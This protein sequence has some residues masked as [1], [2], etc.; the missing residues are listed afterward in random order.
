M[1]QNTLA[2][3]NL[4]KV[5]GYI[6]AQ[7]WNALP[8][9]GNRQVGELNARQVRAMMIVYLRDKEGK[10]PLTLGE[11]GAQLGMRKAAASLLVSDFADKRLLCRAV[12]RDN[13]RFIRITLGV[14]GRRLGDAV[15]AQASI[16]ITEFLTRLSREEQENFK[17]IADK[18]YAYYSQK[19]EGEE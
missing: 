3:M 6:Q 2:F 10:T 8:K 18:I 12:D 15:T 1:D 17:L 16:Q 7:A 11:L 19:V 13:R 14:K 5:F 4:Y 9:E